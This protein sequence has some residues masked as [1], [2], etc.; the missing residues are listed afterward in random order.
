MP[1]IEGSNHST[2]GS[3]P[4]FALAGVLAAFALTTVL[5]AW[6]PGTASA[7]ALTCGAVITHDTTL[8]N[9]LTDCP[10][11]GLVIGADGVTL[12]L[13][14]H[15]VAGSPCDTGCATDTG[16]D[17]TGGY[18]QVRI[19]NG[20]VQG[21]EQLIG[22]VGAHENTLA[23]LTVGGFPVSTSFIGIS[24]SHSHDN[25]L[26]RITAAGGAP[27]VSLSASDRNTITDSSIDGGVS[28]RVGRSIT[29]A[30]GSD[31][32]QIE[33]SRLDGEEGAA[34]YD[35]TDNRL[36]R[37]RINGGSDAVGLAGAHRTVIGHNTLTSSG[38]G[39]I[40]LVMYSDSD[41]NV[42]RDNDMPSN[43]MW[44]R[45]DHNEIV[46]NDAVGRFPFYDQSVIE[47]FAGAGNVLLSNRARGGADD[48]AVRANATGTL[49]QGNVVTAAE[50]DG[51]DV[52][53]PG[54]VVRANSADDNGDLGIE[55]AE[56]V[57][58]GGGNRASGNGNLLQ[59][60]NVVCR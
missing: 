20:T 1:R 24:L 45:G 14:G 8:E 12:D 40:T 48:I 34:I 17:N 18:D 32:N 43:G 7:Q 44:I 38:N 39:A 11:D 21:F 60:V 52:D 27:A 57:I 13:N 28:I 2:S 46:R 41:E 26:E 49:V 25:A 10:G 36:V 19:V 42:I 6:A 30:D 54:T 22:L 37:N 31:A 3:R 59:C 9:D 50:D 53:A 47:V 35:S 51:I 23:G 55:A 4:M 15:L 58:D 16:I 56:G 33:R 29:L 5:L